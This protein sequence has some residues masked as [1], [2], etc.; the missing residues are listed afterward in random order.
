MKDWQ[1]RAVDEAEE[2][3]EKL[4]KLAEFLGSDSFYKLDNENQI[5]LTQQYECMHDYHSVLRSRIELFN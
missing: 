2:L 4:M 3:E 5:L 1:Q